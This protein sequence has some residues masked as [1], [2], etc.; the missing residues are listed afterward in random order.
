MSGADWLLPVF[1]E[2]HV[3]LTLYKPDTFMGR[4]VGAG[5]EG[6]RLRER[7]DCTYFNPLRE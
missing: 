7:V 6:V 1:K 4:T 2:C 3:T 5:P